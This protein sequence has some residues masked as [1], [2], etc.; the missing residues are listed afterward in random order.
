MRA[1]KRYVAREN[2]AALMTDQPGLAARSSPPTALT[3]DAA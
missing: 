1:L 3:P 2:Y